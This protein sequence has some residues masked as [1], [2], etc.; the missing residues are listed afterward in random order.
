MGAALALFAV[1]AT[2]C[3]SPTLPLPPPEA[4]D[5]LHASSE[6]GVWQVSGACSP[7]ARVTVLNEATG[8]GAVFEDRDGTGRYSV[9]IEALR[10]EAGSVTQNFAD[11]PTSLS[12]GAPFV[13]QETSS[14]TPKDPTEC[15]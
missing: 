5:V 8:R 14:G 4:P 7:G 12:A 2:S 1:V 10:C 15:H 13:F 11:D 9:D 6:P 3:L